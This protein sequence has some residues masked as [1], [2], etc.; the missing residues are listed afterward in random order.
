LAAP[1]DAVDLAR[2]MDEIISGRYNWSALRASA[3]A[4]H[5]VEFSDRAMAAGVA[6]V[7][8]DVLSV[9]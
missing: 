3:M 6:A 5:A 2:A 8:R 9:H 7:Y 1:G 4:R